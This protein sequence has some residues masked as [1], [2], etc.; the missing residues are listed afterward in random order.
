[1]M[2]PIQFWFDFSSPYAYIA[3]EQ[4]EVLAAKH[5]RVVDWRVVMIGAVFKNA[6]TGPLTTRYPPLAQYAKHDFARSARF[7]NVPYTLPDPFPI[8]S[9]N[10]ARAL[11]WMQAHAPAHATSFLHAAFQGLF[12]H[13]APIN[14]SAWIEKAVNACGANGTAAVAACS[15]S[16]IK[17][18]LKAHTDEAIAQ[19]IF[20]VPWIVADGETFWGND[21]LPQLDAW[22][23]KGRF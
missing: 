14:N 6:G 1:M 20:G 19:G 4:I 11:L 23:Q 3:S 18:Q 22:L 9:Q 21:R 12:V 2:K 17:D 15:D 7:C 8:L 13:N 10:T 5:N 16:A